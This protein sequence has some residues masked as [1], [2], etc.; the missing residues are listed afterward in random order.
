[1]AAWNRAHGSRLDRAE[2]AIG[3][4]HRSGDE[5]TLEHQAAWLRLALRTGDDAHVAEAFANAEPLPLAP[6]WRGPQAAGFL[7]GW[8][9]KR[10][11]FTLLVSNLGAVNGLEGLSSVAFWPAVHGRSGVAVGAASVGAQTT[12]TVRAPR[13][14]FEERDTWQL[15]EAVVVEL[16][17][18]R[19]G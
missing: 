17:L 12:I 18:P 3:A 14:S 15:A 11:G 4:S 7:V 10:I 6:A 1:M 16:A 5:I 19:R 2:V 9:A 13:R 8:L